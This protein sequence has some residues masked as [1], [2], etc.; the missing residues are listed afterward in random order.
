MFGFQKYTLTVLALACVSCATSVPPLPEELRPHDS[1][2]FTPPVMGRTFA[3]MAATPLDA[4]DMTTSS[5]WAGVLKGA[6]YMVEV[7]ANWNGKLV[8]FAHGYAG[9]GP[10]LSVAPPAIR[11]HL[12]QSGYAWAASS[13]STN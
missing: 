2:V 3:A 8:M 12:L 10:A 5:R 7:P 1:R 9:T 13:Y 6:A 11:R 4:I